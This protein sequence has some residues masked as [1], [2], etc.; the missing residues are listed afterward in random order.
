MKSIIFL[1]LFGFGLQTCAQKNYE[2]PGDFKLVL[3]ARKLSAVSYFKTGMA[4]RI[5]VKDV[6]EK[7]TIV[8]GYI[9]HLE[10][11]KIII[12]SFNNKSGETFISPATIEN[13]RPLSRRGRKTA[14]IIL[15][16]GAVY[17]GL[18]GLISNPG[19]LQYVVFLPA[20]GAGLFF[21]YYYPVTFI[22]DS[23]RQ[24]NKKNGWF[25]SIEMRP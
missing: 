5:V 25:F 23:I 9:T 20:M 17:A 19:L 8:R 1:M 2:Q 7:K 18:M 24:K 11:D 16:G 22:F 4:V 12:G 13:I 3:T 21:V 14:A 10:K 6:S 15:G